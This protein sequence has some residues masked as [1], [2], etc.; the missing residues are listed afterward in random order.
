[1]FS[2][3]LSRSKSFLADPLQVHMQ[4]LCENKAIEDLDVTIT[5]DG[6]FNCNIY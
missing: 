3:F 6:A 4:I 2:F 5:D 1:M